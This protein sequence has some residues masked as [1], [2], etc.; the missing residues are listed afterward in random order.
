M[1]IRCHVIEDVVSFSWISLKG[2]N[3]TSFE[4]PS[5]ALFNYPSPISIQCTFQKLLKYFGIFR[6]WLTSSIIWQ[7]KLFAH[8]LKLVPLV[9]SNNIN[10]KNRS[11][12]L[13]RWLAYFPVYS[14]FCDFFN[15]HTSYIL[16][17]SDMHEQFIKWPAL[18]STLTSLS[19][20]GL[21][22]FTCTLCKT[23]LLDST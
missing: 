11:Y 8:C 7:S 22:M 6:P 20:V 1:S 4:S 23:S 10:L 16:I 3:H 12:A 15:G 18:L 5:S 19:F 13:I 14:C 2:K 9:Y 17:G 21:W